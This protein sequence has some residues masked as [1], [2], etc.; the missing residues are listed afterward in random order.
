MLKGRKRGRGGISS[1]SEL[2]ELFCLVVVII[3][4]FSVITSSTLLMMLT[5]GP[6]F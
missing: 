5:V 3:T 4:I 6:K 1:S 2:G